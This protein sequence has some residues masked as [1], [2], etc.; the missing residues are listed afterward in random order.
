VSFTVISSEQFSLYSGNPNGNVDGINAVF[1]LTYPGTTNGTIVTI[2]GVVQLPTSAYSISGGGYT[3]TFTEPPAIGD[4]IDVRV[5]TTTTQVTA[6]SGTTGYYSVTA[7]N[8]NVYI[9]TGATTANVTTSWIAGGAEVNSTP[10]VTITTSGLATSVDN[11]SSTVYSSAEYTAT[12]TIAGTNIREISKVIVVT[13]GTAAV[14]NQYA[15]A[16]SAGN[17]LVAY[18]ATVAGG[19][20]YLQGTATNN[21]T[22]VRLHKNYQ[23]I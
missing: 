15:N 17:S 2:N 20:A 22:I 1:T 16:R 19:V 14:V 8:S 18:S 3:L 7:N 13:D 9:T 4:V 23:A 10:N 21:N 5:L 11:W 12:A 6:L